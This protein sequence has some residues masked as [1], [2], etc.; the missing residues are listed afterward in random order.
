MLLT[1]NP[2]RTPLALRAHLRLV[3]LAA[4]E[5]CW[6]YAAL[7]T[8][9]TIAGM[10]HEVSPFGIFLV[11][12]AGLLTGRILP[13]SKLAWRVLQF[14]TIAIA[15]F[16]ILFAIRIGLYT[17]VPFA[18]VSWLPE[19][20]GRT[21]TFFQR[22][23]PEALSTVAL[24]FSFVRALGFAQRPLTLWQ[25]GFQFRLG[26]VIFF[27]TALLA[28]LTRQTD[29]I[30]W[31]FIYFGFSLCGISLAR[32]EE[33]GQTQPLSWRWAVI[34]FIVIGATL[35][36][37]LIATRLFTL[38]V[39]D[40][41]FGLLS[42]LWLAIG[43]VIALLAFPFVYL[44]SLLVDLLQ[45]LFEQFRRFLQDLLARLPLPNNTEPPHIPD[46]LTQ[47]LT[48]LLPYLRFI[49]VI[50]VVILIGWI[51]ARALHR[52]MKQE[53]EEMFMREAA[54]ERMTATAKTKSPRPA[55]PT[56]REMNAESVRRIY[57]ALQAHAESLGLARRDAETPLEYLPRLVA[58]FPASST[59]LREITNAYVAVHYAQKPAD[60]DQVHELRAIWQRTKSAM[61]AKEKKQ[62]K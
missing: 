2:F 17:D 24:I 4:A 20:F 39:V 30:L 21:L 6:I 35:L 18:D 62:S 60:A 11:Y 55:R 46:Q 57:A 49:S 43:I 23:T 13:R 53:E 12:W 5:A 22:M 48:S 1:A 61:S 50:L 41:F 26:I 54:D 25:V 3:L 32:I 31:I 8:F 9:G 28:A 14:A 10:P 51:I 15:F 27:F 58:R 47:Q 16:A 38:A 56:R 19:Y 40:A 45:P 29:F 59:D 7:L 52:L 42:P 34:F 44:F 33:A 36:L 37:G